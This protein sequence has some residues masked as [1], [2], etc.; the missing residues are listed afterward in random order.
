ML[1]ML[2]RHSVKLISASDGMICTINRKFLRPPFG[3]VDFSEW[4]T[5]LKTKMGVGAF[6]PFGEVDFSEWW[7]RMRKVSQR[8]GG[9]FASVHGKYQYHEWKGNCNASHS[10]PPRASISYK[11]S[12]HMN[13]RWCQITEESPIEWDVNHIMMIRLRARCA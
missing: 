8:L 6:P 2:R 11:M 3:E 13:T 1:I 4:W 5:A 7:S 10:K 9:Q 12:H